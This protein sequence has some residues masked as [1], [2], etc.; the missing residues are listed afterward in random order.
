[1]GDGFQLGQRAP[2]IF[3][4]WFWFVYVITNLKQCGGFVQG[5]SWRSQHS[6]K[7]CYHVVFL[8]SYIFAGVELQTERETF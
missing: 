1:M 5:S 7:S 6:L 8:P 4:Y 2:L 3:I